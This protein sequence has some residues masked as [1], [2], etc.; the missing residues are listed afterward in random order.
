MTLPSISVEIPDDG[1]WRRQIKCQFACPVNTDA[2]GYVRAIARGDFETAYLIARGP[3]P[4]ASICGRVCGAPCEAAC[5]R[6]SIDDAVSIRALKRFVTERHGPEAFT[7]ESLKPIEMLKRV[8]GHRRERACSGVEE[9]GSFTVGLN[10]DRPSGGPKVAIIGSGPAGLAAAHD[11]ALLGCKPTVFEM[12]AVPAGMLAVGIPEYRLPRDLIEAEVEVIR[13]VGVEFVCNTQV[14]KDISLAD[15]RRDFKATIIAVGAKRSRIVPIPGGDGPGVLGGVEFLRDIA[16][17]DRGVGGSGKDDRPGNLAKTLGQRIVVVG[18]GNVAY[19][20]S[21]TVIRQIGYDVSRSALRESTVREVHLCCLESVDEMPAD[22]VEILEG[23]EEGVA[24][25]PSLGPAE[26]LRDESGAVRG[27]KFNRCTRVFDENGRFAPQFDH[28]DQVVIE[29]DTVVWAIGQQADVS[30]ADSADDVARNER[31]LIACD[32]ET[33]ETS[34][35]DVFLAGDIAYGPRL[36]IDAVASGKKCARTVHA[37]LTGKRPEP[38]YEFVHLNV[39]DY[40]RERD[41]EKLPR[42]NISTVDAEARRTSQ[43]T[44]VECGYDE[45][46]AVTEACRCL[47]CGVNTVFDSEKCILCGGCADV[48]PELCLK[49][50][51]CDRL[52]GDPGLAALLQ[53]RYAGADLSDESA[54]IKDEEKCIR[55]ALCAERCPVGAITMERFGFTGQWAQAAT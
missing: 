23:H 30:F 51:S 25:H 9:L 26:V 55:C 18:G 44:V 3:N 29:A 32:Q 7:R 6:A 47:D 42:T 54:I 24:L 31:G 33:M 35:P 17:R 41:Y 21:R 40:A 19:D 8:L 1:Y 13:S 22:D 12:E 49:L 46:Q 39:V 34:A 43:T 4:L 11:L 50:V 10:G 15:I 48:C 52:A 20:V 45:D 36:L 53:D 16:L 2:R 5:R 14:G 28:D 27:V 37:Y 38:T